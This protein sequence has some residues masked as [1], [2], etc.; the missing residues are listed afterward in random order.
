MRDSELIGNP[1]ASGANLKVKLTHHPWAPWSNLSNWDEYQ[2]RIS[3]QALHEQR[4]I[5]ATLPLWKSNSNSTL[6]HT[7]SMKK[8]WGV[9]E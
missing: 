2:R 1:S 8:S 5:K 7:S 6:M 4:T 3:S 9:L